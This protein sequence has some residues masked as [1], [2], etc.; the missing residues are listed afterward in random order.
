MDQKADERRLEHQIELAERM[1]STVTDRTTAQR[2]RAFAQELARILQALLITR[3]RR[4]Q[5]R[6]RAYQLWENAGRPP[7]RDQEFW[8]QAERELEDGNT[9]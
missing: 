1:A 5:T 2:F 8:L 9:D 3:R 7:G 4:Q 6:A